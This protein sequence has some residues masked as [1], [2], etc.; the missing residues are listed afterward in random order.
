MDLHIFPILNP[1]PTSLPIPSLWVFPDYCFN[2]R[3]RSNYPFLLFKGF[4][5]RS[6]NF[7]VTSDYQTSSLL[8]FDLKLDFTIIFNSKL[9]SQCLEG[10]S[11]P[12][13]WEG[14]G[15]WSVPDT[16]RSINLSLRPDPL[17]GWGRRWAL[18][19]SLPYF[20][21]FLGLFRFQLLV[22]PLVFS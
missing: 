20:S 7:L 6:N 12:K 14:F 13:G 3:E 18:R 1:P 17:V 16:S 5:G 15:A 4:S 19:K 2:H 8:D 10:L 11:S 22:Y 9:Y 21:G